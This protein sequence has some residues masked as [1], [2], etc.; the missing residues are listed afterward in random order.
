MEYF[1][2][3]LI[4]RRRVHL[5]C[6]LLR[7]D[8]CSLEVL[9]CKLLA[10][11]LGEKRSRGEIAFHEE[12]LEIVLNFENNGRRNISLLVKGMLELD[13]E[14][15]VDAHWILSSSSKWAILISTIEQNIIPNHSDLAIRY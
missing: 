10:V 4:K 3:F 1:T 7:A 2:D 5:A 6:I 12:L 9:A 15:R 14:R 13:I 11:T 8:I